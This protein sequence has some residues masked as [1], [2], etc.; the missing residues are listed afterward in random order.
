MVNGVL[1]LSRSLGKAWYA[2]FWCH[3]PFRWKGLGAS[4]VR[5]EHELEEGFAP[6][7]SGLRT[8]LARVIQNERESRRM[9]CHAIESMTRKTF[10]G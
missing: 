5:R 1:T 2:I 4:Y 6:S 10:V 8:V 7:F 9:G 3:G